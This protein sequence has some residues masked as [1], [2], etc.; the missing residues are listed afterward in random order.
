MELRLPEQ[1]VEYGGFARRT[2][3]SKLNA[4]LCGHCVYLGKRTS[5][6]YPRPPDNTPIEDGY[7]TPWFV[8]PQRSSCFYKWNGNRCNIE[9]FKY[10]GTILIPVTT[11]NKNGDRKLVVD[12]ELLETYLTY[13]C[14][15]GCNL[16]TCKQNN[17]NVGYP[18]PIFL[19]K[20][21]L[22]IMHNLNRSFFHTILCRGDVCYSGKASRQRQI[23]QIELDWRKEKEG[24]H[25]EPIILE[26]GL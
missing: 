12:D 4:C 8:H 5:T 16:E 20:E 26:E 2:G 23:K 24:N 18:C 6:S 11:K 3:L 17:T 15:T 13:G 25:T 10:Y 1:I 14:A 21:K 19:L 7:D 9:R 22:G